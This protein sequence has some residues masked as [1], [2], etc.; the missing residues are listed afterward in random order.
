MAGAKK[1]VLDE[2]R[3]KISQQ[4]PS[5]AAA[6]DARATAEPQGDSPKSKP[7]ETKHPTRS[8]ATPRPQ[9]E[10]PKRS[11]RGMQFYLE[12]SDRKIIHSLAVWFG[13]Q[14]RR[15]SDSQVVKAAI[16]LAT[17]QQNARL[18]A[19]AD[20]VRATDRR[21]QSSKIKKKV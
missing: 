4:L 15:V 17:A 10:I 3:N 19:I 1:N 2:L 16:R 9:P 11:G 20:E 13:S 21:H 7:P 12:D 8:V 18:L 5:K 6:S 14:D